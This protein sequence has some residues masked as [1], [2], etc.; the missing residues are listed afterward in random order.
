MGAC[1]TAKGCRAACLIHH[2]YERAEKH[3][4]DEDT[5]VVGVRKAGN[6]AVLH[7]VY[8]CSFKSEFGIEKTA[9][10]NADKEGRI[11]L[12]GD[13]GE[14]DSDNR[15][16]DCPD[17]RIERCNVLADLCDGFLGVGADI[18]VGTDGRVVVVYVGLCESGKLFVFRNIA[19]KVGFEVFECEYGIAGKRSVGGRFGSGF[20]RDENVDRA[21]HA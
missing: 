10:Q 11:H 21:H 12:F 17:R 5:D 20:R 4:E 19:L 18:G 8:K 14:G 3:E 7:N 1:P 15:R 6:E 2:A 9:G 13:K 16:K